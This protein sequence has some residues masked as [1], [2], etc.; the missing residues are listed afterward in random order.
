MMIKVTYRSA[1]LKEFIKA[2][3]LIIFCTTLWFQVFGDFINGFFRGLAIVVAVLC[4]LGL[5]EV[6]RYIRKL[7]STIREVYG[8][9]WYSD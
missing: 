9:L 3:M 5:I 2:L 6:L 7:E 4:I 1:L 8:E